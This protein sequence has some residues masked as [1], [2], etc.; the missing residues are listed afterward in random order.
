[1]S[2]DSLPRLINLAHEVCRRRTHSC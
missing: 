1:M 2:A